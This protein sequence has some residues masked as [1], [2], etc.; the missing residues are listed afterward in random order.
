MT[1][2]PGFAHHALVYNS[3]SDLLGT[4]IPFLAEGLAAGQRAVL[5]ARPALARE[6]A[7]AMG[8]G[9][10][11]RVVDPAKVYTGSARTVAAFR[12]LALDGG[13]A[14]AGVRVVASVP[15]GGSAADQE[16]LGRYEA[17]ANAA[18][19]PLAL[20]CLCAYDGRYLPAE[21]GALIGRTHPVVRASGGARPSPT[22]TDPGEFL[23]GTTSPGPERAELSRPAVII[24]AITAAYDMVAARFA[25]REALARARVG[26]LMASDFAAAVGE[27]LANAV[28]HGR[29][30]AQL[31]LWVAVDQLVCTV[32]D[33]GPGFDDPLAG[34][35]PPFPDGR[36]GAG[37]WLA[38]QTCDRLDK[39]ADREWFSVRVTTFLNHGPGVA[40]AAGAK[41]RAELALQRV[42]TTRTR[43]ALRTGQLRRQ[44]D[45]V[46]RRADHEK[47]AADRA[48]ELV[49]R[50]AART[51]RVYRGEPPASARDYPHDRG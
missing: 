35:L 32:R 40:R 27:L 25:V 28:Q 20:S 5:V 19:A 2:S 6:M 9:A 45:A 41:A 48:A 29:P 39:W 13:A 8:P 23:A 44:E 18:L 42:Q 37:L 21:V 43:V 7:A 26:E 1:L 33:R 24:P 4:A 46:A 12:R 11:L 30:P 17:V 31:R 36:G 49:R 22:F 47:A 16:E 3:V 51:D 15:V 34:Y 50:A 14:R 38:R 10:P